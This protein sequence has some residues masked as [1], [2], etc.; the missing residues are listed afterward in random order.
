MELAIDPADLHAASVVLARCS[1]TLSAAGTT[2]AHRA[3]ADVPDLGA[4]ASSA[5]GRAA[6]C[7][8]HA[9]GVLTADIARLADALAT[10]AH[11]YPQV[12]RAVA[13]QR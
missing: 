5:S 9:V 11:H 6:Q 1:A 10:L 2:F 8:D 7:A 13:S 12:D 4:K 3:R